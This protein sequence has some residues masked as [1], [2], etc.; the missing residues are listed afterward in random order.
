MKLFDYFNSAPP[1]PAVTQVFSSAEGGVCAIGDS[2]SDNLPLFAPAGI[3]W[4]PPDGASVVLIPFEDCY[5]CVG[6]LC[7]ADGLSKG[8]LRLK[9][10]GGAAIHLKQNGDVVINRLVIKPDG[11]TVKEADN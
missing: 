4:L 7:S 8:E 1:A 6:S 11:T 10:A 5:L 2:E 9:S 3:D